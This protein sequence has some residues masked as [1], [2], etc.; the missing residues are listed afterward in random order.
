MLLWMKQKSKACVQWCF[1]IIRQYTIIWSAGGFWIFWWR[2][3]SR[4]AIMVMSM[5]PRLPKKAPVGEYRGVKMHL[6][7]ADYVKF[8]PTLV[9]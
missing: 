8:I 6:I 4:T 2:E 9:R 1:F 3:E 5:E 7:S